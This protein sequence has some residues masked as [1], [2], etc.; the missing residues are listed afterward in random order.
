MY[1]ILMHGGTFLCWD[2]WI[3]CVLRKESELFT[4]Y[5]NKG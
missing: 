4:Y 5:F 2:K 3:C 1:E